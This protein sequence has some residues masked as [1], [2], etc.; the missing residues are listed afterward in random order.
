MIMDDEPSSILQHDTPIPTGGKGQ[1]TQELQLEPMLAQEKELMMEERKS[2]DKPTAE[3]SELTQQQDRY[4]LPEDDEPDLGEEID[5]VEDE[6]KVVEKERDSLE[7]EDF[8]QYQQS[9]KKEPSHIQVQD[10]I[11]ED[12]DVPEPVQERESPVKDVNT[13][14]FG[15]STVL[16]GDITAIKPPSPMLDPQTKEKL[17]NL[18]HSLD[19]KKLHDAIGYID[20]R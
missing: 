9:D 4:Q 20:L 16:Q 12:D 17:I 7:D 3:K 1:A 10:D 15:D 5:F 14:Q 8:A 19:S 13:N 11:K 18:G 6:S 2:E